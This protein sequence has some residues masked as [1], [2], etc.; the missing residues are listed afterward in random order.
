MEFPEEN[1]NPRIS[2]PDADLLNIA[3]VGRR[4]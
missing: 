3:V 2:I 4:L 1:G